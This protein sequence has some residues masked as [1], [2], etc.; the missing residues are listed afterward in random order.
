MDIPAKLGIP[1]YEF[2]VVFGQMKIDYDPGKEDINRKKHGYS[3]ESAVLLLER[4]ILQK[5]ILPLCEHTPYAR[6]DAF[7]EKG[8][9][10]HMHMSVDDCGSVVFMVT[11]MRPGETIRII[12]FRHAHEKEREKFRELTG[13]VEP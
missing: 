1:N 4:L 5:V 7:E 8:E 10:R 2:R 6:S 9:A 11:T 12:S 3:L 13:Y